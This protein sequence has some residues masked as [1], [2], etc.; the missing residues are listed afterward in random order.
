MPNRTTIQDILAQLKILQKELT[1]AKTEARRQSL[2]R[3]FRELFDEADRLT[4]G[5][6][7]EK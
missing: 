6:T 1:E 7:S 5:T 4:A 3:Q 2:L